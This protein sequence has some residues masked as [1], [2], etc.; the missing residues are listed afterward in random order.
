MNL[1]C[2]SFNVALCWL[3]APAALPFA[4]LGEFNKSPA[5][6]VMFDPEPHTGVTEETSSCT[7]KLDRKLVRKTGLWLELG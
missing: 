7:E 6:G 1:Y 4:E 2:V 5:L 3:P